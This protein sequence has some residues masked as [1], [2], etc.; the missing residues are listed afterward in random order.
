[1]VII[2]EDG[3]RQ[4]IGIYVDDSDV[5]PCI[6]SIV[7]FAQNGELLVGEKALRQAVVN[8]HSTIYEVKRLMGRSYYDDPDHKFVYRV[9][10]TL[11]SH[12]LKGVRAAVEIPCG[13]FR[14]KLVQPELISALILRHVADHAQRYFGVAVKD[15]VISVPAQFDD[16]QRKATMDAGLI[17]GLNPVKIVN[18]PT[19]AVFAANSLTEKLLAANDEIDNSEEEKQRHTIW[20]VVADIG[21]GTT[22]YALMQIQGSFY[23][24]ITTDGDKT[25]GGR[26]IDI[27]LTEEMTRILEKKYSHFNLNSSEFQQKLRIECENAKIVLSEKQQYSLTVEYVDQGERTESLPLEHLLT[28]VEFEEYVSGILEAMIKPL[29]SLLTRA[30]GSITETF[31]QGIK[32][33]N[34]E[35]LYLVGGTSQIPK[36]KKLLLSYFSNVKNVRHKDPVQLVSRGAAAFGAALTGLVQVG[37]MP[38]IDAVPLPISIAVDM[39]DM[40]VIFERNRLYPCIEK[41]TLT[42]YTNNQN[43]IVIEVYEGEGRTADECHFLGEFELS[44][45]PPL[46]KNVPEIQATFKIDTNGILSVKASYGDMVKGMKLDVY[47]KSGG[48]IGKTRDKMHLILSQL[49]SPSSEGQAKCELLEDA[50]PMSVIPVKP[51]K[52]NVLK[53]SVDSKYDSVKMVDSS[54]PNALVPAIGMVTVKGLVID[55]DSVTK[56]T[57]LDIVLVVDLSGSMAGVPISTMKTVILHLIDS[58]KENHRLGIV[59]YATNVFRNL[60]LVSCTAGNMSRARDIVNDFWIMS[61][62]NLYGG[63][64]SGLEMAYHGG[65][66]SR[67]LLFTDGHANDGK[68]IENDDIIREIVR[69]TTAL[70]SRTQAQVMLSTFGYLGKHDELLLKKLATY[71]GGGTYNFVNENTALASTF[72]KV[73]GDAIHTIAEKI[74]LS[75]TPLDKVQI[76]EAITNFQTRQE[77]EKLIFEIPSTADQQSRHI[78]LRLAVPPTTE[79]SIHAGLY[80]VELAYT[81]TL[82]EREEGYYY[83]F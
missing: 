30:G 80:R 62:T 47:S 43:A 67:V 35:D 20:A 44:G 16:A 24:V 6:P 75:I 64:L 66:R 14:K 51:R 41:R 7:A 55:Y 15:V 82:T 13:K 53:L 83:Y 57:N 9:R 54:D 4:D 72:A 28:R 39:D 34:I 36:L 12:S 63:L 18:E 29:H 11:K 77:S 74:E 68:W 3:T 70:R 50:T 42:T 5:D 23:K 33:E 60:E 21:G 56:G 48:M 81:N 25:L 26:E 69:E 40:H 19:V 2:K 73:L 71:V 37:K 27:R 31:G 61:S 76:V 10:P 38:R 45:I 17:A 59:T 65:R 1:M 46:P 52:S 22:D 32:A 49:M 8:P 78:L 58:L 79:P